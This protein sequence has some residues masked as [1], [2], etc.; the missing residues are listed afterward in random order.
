MEA[1]GNIST[2]TEG[3]AQS[4]DRSETDRRWR[5]AVRCFQVELISFRASG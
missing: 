4:E 3:S 1:A 2:G 5:C